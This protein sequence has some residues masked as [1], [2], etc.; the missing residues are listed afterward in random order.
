[1]FNVGCLHFSF[2][3]G[4]R[5]TALKDPNQTKPRSPGG[6]PGQTASSPHDALSLGN[7]T[8]T[9]RLIVGTGK[10][11]DY[12][13]MAESLEASG[14][15]CITVAV[16]RERLIDAAG[17]NLLDFIDTRRYIL[18]PNTAGCFTADDAIRVARLG[19]EI[20]LGLENPGADWVKLE[21]L[22]DK[23]TL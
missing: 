22:S 1:M 10:Y 4:D 2:G 11:A 15:E 20:L 7:H 8:L 6:A 5:V 16:R 18:L 3:D 13:L 12:Q 23:P 9:S 21:V 17:N 14:T 19:R